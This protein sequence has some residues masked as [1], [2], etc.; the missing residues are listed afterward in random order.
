MSKKRISK[1]SKIVKCPMQNKSYPV[2][3]HEI[4]CPCCGKGIADGSHKIIMED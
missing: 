1:Y 2:E 4:I 3:Q